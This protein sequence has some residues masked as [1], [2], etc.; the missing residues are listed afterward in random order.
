MISHVLMFALLAAAPQVNINQARQSYSGCLGTLL[1]T[2]LKDRVEPTTF[3][4][5]LASSCKAEE[6]AFRQAVVSADVAAGTSRTSAEQGANFE[7]TD[8]VENTKQTYKAYV[9]TNTQP[10]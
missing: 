6:S 5:T 10:R 8:M 2:N 1:R 9:E 7:I 3:E 4:T